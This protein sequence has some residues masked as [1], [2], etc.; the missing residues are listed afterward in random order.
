MIPALL[1][2]LSLAAA[3][4]PPASPPP[5]TADQLTKVRALVQ[6]TQTDHAAARQTLAEAQEE[7]ARCYA[8]YELDEKEVSRLQTVILGE[9]QKLLDSH[10]RLQK[11]LRSIVGPERFLV[12]SRRIE[13][14]LKSPPTTKKEA[15]PESPRQ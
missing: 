10:H 3:D 12:L 7:L 13:N 14:V 8:K 4:A 9:Q 6:Q 15:A 11:E 1:L 2:C 5:L